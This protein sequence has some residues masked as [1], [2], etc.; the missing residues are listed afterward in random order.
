MA[1]PWGS[2]PRIKI[3][4]QFMLIPAG[5]SGVDF[6]LILKTQEPGYHYT[7]SVSYPSTSNPWQLPIYAEKTLETRPKAHNIIGRGEV[8]LQRV[9]EA[10]VPAALPVVKKLG[11]ENTPTSGSEFLVFTPELMGW[12]GTG[13]ITINEQS[14]E[15]FQP[16]SYSEMKR[17]EFAIG[18]PVGVTGSG[19]VLH[20]ASSDYSMTFPSFD[21]LEER[22]E[23]AAT[24]RKV[25]EYIEGLDEEET[26][27]DL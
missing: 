21:T 2:F 5:R 24:L 23:R 6:K 27:Y 17:N 10:V 1:S 18:M 3:G 8:N 15:L 16:V 13:Q 25:D 22:I 4:D 12:F 20:T 11:P 14:L 9:V 7:I 19:I 26:E